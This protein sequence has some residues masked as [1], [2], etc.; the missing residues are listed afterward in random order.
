MKKYTILLLS[1]FWTA[2]AF[3]QDVA[4]DVL[5]AEAQRVA[6]IEKISPAVVAIF[7]PDG[8]G[9]GS[10]VLVTEDGYALTN[11]HVVSGNKWLKCGLAGG[12]VYDAVT[13]GIDP[14]GDVALIKMLPPEGEPD[15]HFP[16]V[17]LGD[18]DTLRQGDLA[19]VL[20]NPFGFATDFSPTVTCGM[21]SGNHRYQFPAGTLLEY[22][23]CIQIDAAINPGNSGG[24]LFDAAGMLVGIN[25]RGSFEKRG[26]VNV[27]V[28]YAISIN[29]I[30]R[31]M[32]HLHAGR[33]VDHATLGATVT[34]DDV[35]RAVVDRI[36]DDTDVYRRGLRESNTITHFGGR[37]IRTPNDFKNMLGTFPKGWV[38]SITFA[39]KASGTAE[40][41]K[42]VTALVR[43]PGVHS[44]AELLKLMS[45]P[46]E[47]NAPPRKRGERPPAPEDTEE[48]APSADAEKE[49]D[50]ESEKDA[51][52]A[53]GDAPS[54]DT[55]KEKQEKQRKILEMM[56]RKK[57][58]PPARV[59][60][61]LEERHG[62]ENYY[63]NRMER[64]RVW[65]AFTA[66][67]TLAEE[68]KY[69][70]PRQAWALE[71]TL[72]SGSRF[73][74]TWR[75]GQCVLKL[76][77]AEVKW[78]ITED[79]TIPPTPADSEFVLP[80]M[81]L[82]QRFLSH[83][84]QEFGTLHYWGCSPLPYFENAEYAALPVDAYPLYD[85]LAG[86]YGGLDVRFFFSRNENDGE[87]KTE[88]VRLVMMEI[89]TPYEGDCW[90]F[91]FRNYK[92][93]HQGRFLPGR[94]EIVCGENVMEE[95][96]LEKLDIH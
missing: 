51:P 3:S 5:K 20:G 42:E 78:N 29:Q 80:G 23:D 50:A 18:S 69:G 49:A 41:R 79:F 8:A 38:T 48:D 44:E 84:P 26:R 75:D 46:E 12:K 13:V 89:T 94:L 59:K 73:S 33:I 15:F 90:E 58:E 70:T 87:E 1:V 54:A 55:E 11:F 65:D 62:W 35:G 64:T 43:L 95:F 93:D 34:A 71:G 72:L 86:H 61:F 7:S 31:F 19:Y 91:R 74:W 52:P 25:G 67:S 60:A 92:T 66:A 17:A 57:P 21:V 77:T 4:E 6:V 27:G 85:V 76:P 9:G 56:A 36:L 2:A 83:G 96:I 39:R 30:K 88:P 16:T 24:P 32:G 47:K 68:D 53:E 40:A 10:G 81:S 22:A 37:R 28:G 82:W 45:P 63:F 14:V